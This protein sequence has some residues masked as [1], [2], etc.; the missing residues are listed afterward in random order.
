M[1]VRLWECQIR[2]LPSRVF[3]AGRHCLCVYL[4]HCPVLLLLE[5]LPAGEVTA[6]VTEVVIHRRTSWMKHR[7]NTTE[8]PSVWLINVCPESKHLYKVIKSAPLILPLL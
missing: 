3:V 1:L 4:L 2:K 6:T 8:V 7:L 5:R